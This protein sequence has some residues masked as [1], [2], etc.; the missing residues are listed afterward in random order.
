MKALS[1][2]L[3][4]CCILAICSHTD[5]QI[6]NL[7]VNGSSTNFTMTSGDSIRWEYNIPIGATASGEL[8]YDVNQN[9]IIDPGIDKARFLFMQTDG[10]TTE[11]GGPPDLDGAVDGHVIFYQRVGI[12][13]GKYVFRLTHNSVSQ[14]VTGTA[15][16][17]SS[18]AHTISGTV[19]PP[20]GKSPQ[21]IFVQA[22]RN[23]NGGLDFWDAVT[24]VSG[25]FAIKMDADTVGNPWRIRLS[26]NYNPFPPT[27]VSPEEISLTITGDHSGNNFVFL[28]AAIA[29]SSSTE[30]MVV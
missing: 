1:C 18:P 15:T 12:A 25:N 2:L 30:T 5:A 9:G 10:D 3:V 7:V 24:D 28:Q 17:L 13:P 6:S 4:G 14:Q 27:V 21:Y 22:K 29:V 19:T 23:E 8:W 11:N 26:D 20:A 16:A